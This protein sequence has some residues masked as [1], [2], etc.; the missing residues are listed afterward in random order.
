MR[1]VN[2]KWAGM[3]NDINVQ[4]TKVTHEKKTACTVVLRNLFTYHGFSFG[5][6]H[7][8]LPYNPVYFKGTEG[9]PCKNHFS[10]S[11]SRSG[12]IADGFPRALSARHC[13]I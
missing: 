11:D 10:F 5:T 9:V 2:V 4:R 3:K 6:H 1:Y 7:I 8:L 13:T 12:K